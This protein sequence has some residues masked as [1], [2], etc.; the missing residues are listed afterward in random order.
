MKIV[1]LRASNL[2]KLTALELK[3]GTKNVLEVT[4][5]NGQGKSSVLDAIWY[6][7]GGGDAIGAEAVKHGAQNA[8][9]TLHLDDEFIV[10]RKFS[11]SGTTNLTIKNKDGAKYPSPQ[12]LLD[13]L[14][15][16]LTF[17]P[18][19]FI[20][21]NP[22]K[23]AIELLK[24][25]GV[26]ELLKDLARQDADDL[27]KRRDLN[28]DLNQREGALA[29]ITS[30]IPKDLP[31]DEID[32]DEMVEAQE[33][34][35]QANH[36]ADLQEREHRNQNENL[37]NRIETAD[38]NI[39]MARREIEQLRIKIAG[40]EKDIERLGRDKA[41][42]QDALNAPWRPPL[43]QDP[44]DL[45][46]KIAEATEINQWLEIRDR[47]DR[48]IEE[49]QG[50]QTQISDVNFAINERKATRENRLAKATW[51]LPGLTIDENQNIRYQGALLAQ[52]STAEQL[53]VSCALA[54]AM[55][56]K[57]RVILIRDGSLLDRDNLGV[58]QELAKTHDY[59]IWVER[60]EAGLGEPLVVLEDGLAK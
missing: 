26:E 12:A 47:R 23:Q 51:P 46:Q 50:L 21:M 60:I 4:G 18:L 38:I 3:P 32:L 52:A 57:L 42:L 11:A 54:M 48:L 49:I 44:G 35:I 58:I 9:V 19:A 41:T 20:S 43:K 5:K 24:L 14:L 10:T 13:R 39:R 37:K 17:D 7:L 59:Q 45:K 25:V 6:T 56:P 40:L 2:K 28:R 53:R 30:D 1:E 8:E 16:R 31:E 33:Q 36:T 22:D 15:G 55:N 34:I 27:V 29:Q